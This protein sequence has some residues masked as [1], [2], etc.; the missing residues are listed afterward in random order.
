MI[1]V[2]EVALHLAVWVAVVVSVADAE[3]PTWWAG[4]AIAALLAVTAWDVKRL[5]A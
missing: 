3:E 1:A 2:A 4:M 5:M